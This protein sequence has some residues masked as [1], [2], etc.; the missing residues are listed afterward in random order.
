VA[1]ARRALA[2]LARVEV[3]VLLALVV[4]TVL[5]WPFGEYAID[6]DWGYVRS[7]EH[8]HRNGVFKILDWFNVSLL[9]QL[10]W[11]LLFTETLGFSF[12]ATK[13]S[14]VVLSYV[15]CVALVAILRHLG[16]SRRLI[17]L[18]A[19]TLLFNP[20]HFFHGFVFDSDVPA[21]AF[22]M[23]ALLFYLQGL[24]ENDRYRHAT[25]L[26]LG[27]L[28]AGL[29]FLVRQ[30]AI[31]LPAALLLFVLLYDRRRLRSPWFLAH[32]FG[33]VALIATVFTYWYEYVHGATKNFSWSQAQT[34]DFILHPSASLL[35]RIAFVLAM[36]VGF[37]VL[38]LILATLPP[39]RAARRKAARR[40]L[41]LDAGTLVPLA[42][43]VALAT[44][45]AYLAVAHGETFPY[46]RNKLTPYGFLR[47][48]EV[49]LG[50]RDVLWPAGTWWIATILCAFSFV[51]FVHQLLAARS[52]GR[53]SPRSA[54]DPIRLV[55]ILLVLQLLYCFPTWTFFF[56]RHLLAFFPALLVL[57]AVAADRVARRAPA[58]PTRTGTAAFAAVIVTFAFYSIAATHDVHA[59]SRLAFRA[60]EDLMRAGVDPHQIDA[61][62]AFDGWYV[63]EGQAGRRIQARA[64]DGWWVRSLFPSIRSDYVVSL[65]PALDRRRL[66]LAI[67]GPDRSALIAPD[68]TGYVVYKTYPYQSFWPF[69]TKTLYV[70]RDAGRP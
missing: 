36:Y 67:T 61:G 14:V 6:D 57:V 30:P 19:L 46:L 35:L 70:L 47:P 48:N 41:P 20:L 45:I 33:P 56:D 51:A 16:V 63:Y 13:L 26:A 39:W 29:A 65:S 28:F 64:N 22:G 59:F 31:V 68:L 42:V 55:G 9:A 43:A 8:L 21:I 44:M 69:E 3:V 49:V 27:S 15:E 37:F 12:T 24:D 4:A 52:A 34:V 58:A 10:F 5:V 53:T 2:A 17:W 60:G 7:L 23:V 25:G 18:A 38:P 50:E 62:Y 32:A 1:P 66:A 54:A 11:A 40:R